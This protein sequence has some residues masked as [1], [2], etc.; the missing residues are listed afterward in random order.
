MR[1]KAVCLALASLM[2]VTV[3]VATPA[4]A[5]IEINVN[6]GDVQPLPIAIPAFGGAR[7]ADIAQVI[8]G[9][10]ER[11]GLFAPIGQQA[12]IEKGL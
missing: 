5:Q 1:L 7:G 2:L 3:S 4:A 6:K 9:N 11:S 10:L 8:T 12:Y